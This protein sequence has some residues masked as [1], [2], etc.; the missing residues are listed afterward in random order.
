LPKNAVSGGEQAKYAN[1]PEEQVGFG[2]SEEE[3]WALFRMGVPH[4]GKHIELVHHLDEQRT[5]K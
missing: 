1:R 2:I 5:V 3:E 4:P